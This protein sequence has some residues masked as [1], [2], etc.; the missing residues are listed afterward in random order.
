MAD[1]VRGNPR[2]QWPEVIAEGIMLHR[3]I[4]VITDSLS[5]VRQATRCFRAQT[6]R[7]APITLDIVW[8]HFL[9][10]HWIQLHPS[11]PLAKFLANAQAAITPHLPGTPEGFQQLNHHLW[12]EH[13]MERYA[14]AN[15]LQQVL[16]GMASRRPRL[17]ALSQSWQDF[18]QNYTLFETLFWQF[19][20]R[21][22]KQA[23]GH[24]L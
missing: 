22:M 23:T 14:D 13:W 8:D 21:M 4:D 20:P 15:R 6:R 24:N 3:R 12:S 2:E 7:V 18:M 17:S 11:Q 9:S 16:N 5:E 1:Y 19:Y 10:R